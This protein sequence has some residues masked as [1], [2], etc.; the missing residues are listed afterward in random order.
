MEYGLVAGVNDNQ[1]EAKK[2]S[3]LIKNMRAHVNLI[4][5]NPIEE[6]D[7]KQP[8]HDNVLKFKQM[9]ERNSIQVTIRR[10]M[11]RDIDGACGQLRRHFIKSD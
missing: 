4:P 3:N 11:G 1:A 5:I 10:E 6:R 9:L 2:L 7:Y 8:S